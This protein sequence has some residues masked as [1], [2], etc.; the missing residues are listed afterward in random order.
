M[1]FAIKLRQQKQRAA[2]P[3][4]K[5]KMMLGNKRCIRHR[6]PGNYGF[7]GIDQGVADVTG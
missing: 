2:R 7:D 6:S 5:L 3:L 4:T 1:I